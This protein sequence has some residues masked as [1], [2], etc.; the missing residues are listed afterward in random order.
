MSPPRLS[1]LPTTSA[2]RR[3]TV[4]DILHGNCVPTC[5]L[6]FRR[7]GLDLPAELWQL[8]IGDWPLHLLNLARGPYE[9]LDREMSVYRVHTEGSWSQLARAERLRG[10]LTFYDFA[11]GWLGPEY[12]R[13]I[14]RKR[15]GYRF[16]QS[17]LG[18][19]TRPLR[20]AL[21][22]RSR[23]AKFRSRSRD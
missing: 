21:R 11:S 2:G 3:I 4:E 16:R 15:R 18:R 14:R 17:R 8:P 20:K 9:Y 19:W 10:S 7:A 22:L 13:M 1:T 5:S 12:S 6:L 23:L